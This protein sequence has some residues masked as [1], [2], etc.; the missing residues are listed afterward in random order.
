M[1]TTL[2][3]SMAHYLYVSS[4]DSSFPGNTPGDFTVSLPKPYDLNGRWECALLEISLH[5][6]YHERLHVCCDIIE[7]SYVNGSSFPVL[8]TL[9]VVKSNGTYLGHDTA[10]GHLTFDRPF[11]FP[12]RKRNIER[13]QLFIRGSRLQPLNLEKPV[14]C[15]LLLRQRRWDP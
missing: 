8:R 5:M 15:V 12:L 4:D 2:V 1:T 13:L 6:P 10:Y 9:P 11:F 7:D 14:Y 3:T